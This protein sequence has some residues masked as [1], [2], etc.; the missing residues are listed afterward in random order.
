VLGLLPAPL[1]DSY[2][3]MV[4]GGGLLHGVVEGGSGRW[5]LTCNFGLLGDAGVLCPLSLLDNLFPSSGLLAL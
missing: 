3:Y 4:S 5:R 1:T 2:V